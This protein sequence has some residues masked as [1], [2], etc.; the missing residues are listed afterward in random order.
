MIAEYATHLRHGFIQSLHSNFGIT[1]S[2]TQTMN[3]R[4]FNNNKGN[5]RG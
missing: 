4:S 2:Y 3:L 5:E 1:S